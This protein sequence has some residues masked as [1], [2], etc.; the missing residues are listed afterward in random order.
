[1]SSFSSSSLSPEDPKGPSLPSASGEEVEVLHQP[2]H[3]IESGAV[4]QAGLA[5]HVKGHVT[6][7][8]F[9]F[10]IDP[11]QFCISAQNSTLRNVSVLEAD[12]F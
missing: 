3:L 11:H 7:D 5:F 4:A 8:F 9:I 1:M 2:A 12:W 10:I 6:Q